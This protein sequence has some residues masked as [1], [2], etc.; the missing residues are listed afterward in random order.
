MG[1]YFKKSDKKQF[2]LKISWEDDI[3]RR[4]E[5]M[6]FI[7]SGKTN[8]VRTSTGV[9]SIL[10]LTRESKIYN[11]KPPCNFFIIIIVI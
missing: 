11:L 2:M 1:K 5:D 4:R 10:F 7:S 8:I 3:T 6:D 9:S